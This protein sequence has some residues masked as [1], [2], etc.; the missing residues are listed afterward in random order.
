MMDDV[1]LGQQIEVDCIELLIENM[2]ELIF[3]NQDVLLLLVWLKNYDDYI[4]EYLVSVCVLFVVFGCGMK[5][6]WEVIKDLVLGGLLYDVG[7]VKVLDSIFNKLVKL[8]DDEYVWIQ[9]YV[10]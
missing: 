10:V 7:K 2:V 4:F 5:L 1:W 3:C 9:L 8:I 6:F